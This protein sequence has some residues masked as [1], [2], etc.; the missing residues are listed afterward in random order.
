M[1]PVGI[2]GNAEE[3]ASRTG[4]GIFDGRYTSSDA[5]VRRE[6]R[7]VNGL[8]YR[9]GMPSGPRLGLGLVEVMLGEMDPCAF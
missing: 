4:M 6:Y 1:V 3:G 8:H 9:E 2:V 5:A 7:A